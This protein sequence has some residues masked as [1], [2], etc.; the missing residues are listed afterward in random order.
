V[1]EIDVYLPIERE[2]LRRARERLV[3][4]G[5]VVDGRGGEASEEF[6]DVADALYG[7]EGVAVAVK[8]IC[9]LGRECGKET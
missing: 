8:Q 7:A 6:I 2:R 9:E 5:V 4:L 3:R 1:R